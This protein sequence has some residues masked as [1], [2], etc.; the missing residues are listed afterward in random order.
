MKKTTNE[1]TKKYRKGTLP[2]G[3]YYFTNGKDI[4]PI[5]H[6]DIGLCCAV[7]GV[8]IVEEVP[9]YKKLSALNEQLDIAVKALE[10]INEEYQILS[11]TIATRISQKALKEIKKLEKKKK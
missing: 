10:K 8:S 6:V 7:K 11:P 9:S 1:L 4:Y 5:E 3:Y 2:G